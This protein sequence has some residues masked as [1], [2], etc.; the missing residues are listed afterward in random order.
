MGVTRRGLLAAAGSVALSAC[1]NDGGGKPGTVSPPPGPTTVTSKALDEAAL[2]RKIASLLVVGFRG[3]RVGPDDWIVRAIRDQG[4]GGV[5]LFDRDQQTGGVRNITSP[6]Q[7]T[8]LV[9]SLRVAAPG[10]RLIVAIDQEGGK[11]S[12]LNPSN[13]FPATMS[14]AEVG[15]ANSTATTRDWARGIV[16]PLVSIG[17]NL[18]FAPVV[19]LAIN[20]KNPA[21]AALGRSFS[22]DPRVVVSCAA[23]EI[24]MHREAGVKTSIKHFP[25]FGSATGNTDFE[26]VDVSGT[27]TRGE[28]EPF[29]RLIDADVVDTVM[30]A[31]LLNRQLDPDLPASLSRAVVNDLLRGQLG[32]KGAVASDDM[33]AVAITGRYGQDE[34]MALALGAGVD[35]FTF[36]NQESHDANVVGAVVGAVVGMVRSGRITEARIDEAVARVD[37]IRG[38]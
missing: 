28:L 32:W 1:G 38:H 10:G 4:L 30:V 20:P 15:A 31:H 16:Q 11:V 8:S 19:D 3:E 21:I 33:Q 12:R 5:I 6:Q 27:W 14:Q 13:G 35:L 37:R 24:R 17:A 25:G 26:V 29:K 7:V 2:R 34:A 22:A 18:N 23:E 36:A 9:R